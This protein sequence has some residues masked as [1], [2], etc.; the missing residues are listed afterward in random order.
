[1]YKI[2]IF[3]SSGFIGRNLSEKL[4]ENEFE[5]LEFNDK[6]L[7]RNSEEYR[8]NLVQALSKFH[9][10]DKIIIINCMGITENN[11]IHSNPD[12]FKQ[13]SINH[14]K[15]HVSV[16]Q[17]FD[18]IFA[19]F[20]LSSG[21]VY[22]STSEIIYENSSTE[23]ITVLG[24][25]KLLMEKIIENELRDYN[26]K[27]I[28]LRLFNVYGADQKQTFL[29]PY[30]ISE[31]K[32]TK[33]IIN[34]GDIYHVRSFIFIE[35]VIEAILTLVKEIHGF[36]STNIFNIGGERSHSIENVVRIISDLTK[37]TKAI[38]VQEIRLRPDE[39]DIEICGVNKLKQL[40]WE[41]K[42]SLQEGLKKCLEN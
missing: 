42:F 18:N 17:Q 23:P 14:E 10:N 40:G 41:Q 30:L 28:I 16:F 27:K 22:S 24:Q 13:V 25:T 29:I 38:H 21:K 5:F 8:L 26:T 37:H 35:D 36:P 20:F 15:L 3:G 9:A 39:S 2:L 6:Y 4:K 34:L 11:F 32:T 31:F 19:Y 7:E 33:P 12:Y 1:M